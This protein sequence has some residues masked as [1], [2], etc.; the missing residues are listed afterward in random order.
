M[1]T[2]ACCF[3]PQQVSLDQQRNVYR[4]MAQKGSVMFFLI[5]D[6]IP[7]NHM[8]QF[9]LAMFLNLFR[10]ALHRE[11]PPGDVASRIAILTDTLLELVM[12]SVSRSLFNGDR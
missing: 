10:G 12:N 8:Y 7:I 3:L 5:R 4:P 1:L 2:F 11:T 6:L 9:S